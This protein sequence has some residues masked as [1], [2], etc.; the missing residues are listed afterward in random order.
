[1]QLNDKAFLD[2]T[3]GKLDFN[4]NNKVSLAEIDKM[5]VEQPDWQICNNKP[6]LM[7]AYKFVFSFVMPFQML[8]VTNF[9][10]AR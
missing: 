1:M 9:C 6:A 3:W 7:R 4:G 8:W 5:I 2:E 10:R